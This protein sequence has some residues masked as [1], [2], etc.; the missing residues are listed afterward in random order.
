MYARRRVRVHM[1]GLAASVEGV[2]VRRRGDY[3]ELAV[4]ELLET[5]S[6]RHALGS[7]AV[8]IEKSRVAFYEILRRP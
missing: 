5:A 8:V 2:L 3:L 6:E 4:P 1:V 7:E